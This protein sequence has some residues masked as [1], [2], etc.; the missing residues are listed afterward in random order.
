LER[1]TPWRRLAVAALVVLAGCGGA[2]TQPP[3]TPTPATDDVGT[4]TEGRTAAGTATGADNPWGAASVTVAVSNEASPWRNVTPLVGAALAYWERHADLGTYAVDWRLRP[5]AEDP[6]LVVRLVEDTAVCGR[7]Q[8]EDVV[9]YAPVLEPG[10]TAD[11]P[12]TVCVRSG[13]ADGALRDVLAH[14]FG[15]VL[16]LDHDDKPQP[17]MAADLPRVPLPEPGAAVREHAWRDDSL[18]VNTSIRGVFARRRAVVEDQVAAALA[19]VERGADGTVDRTVSVE[20]TADPEAADV[21]FRWR[22]RSPCG[23]PES[24]VCG[25]LVERSDGS[26]QLRVTATNVHEDVV[27]WYLAYWLLWTF[28]VDHLSAF[29]EAVQSANYDQ[30]RAAWWRGNAT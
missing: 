18:T 2:P 11:R 17:L 23:D 20:R 15:H 10:D 8:S 7:E 14:E 3:G 12:E 27:G 16:G 25:E 22:T 29:P 6:D 13:L 28:D 5:A 26:P 19:Y 9:G 30:R 21:V 24:G 4:A 1:R